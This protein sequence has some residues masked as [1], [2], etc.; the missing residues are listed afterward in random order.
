MNTRSLCLTMF[1][2]A[3]GRVHAQSPLP[4]TP[5][6]FHPPPP[7][8]AAP[9]SPPSDPT[10]Q[11][12]A[13]TPEQTPAVA[14][15]GPLPSFYYEEAPPEP[16]AP[17]PV[18]PPPAASRSRPRR[19]RKAPRP[20]R[21][22]NAG[23]PFA[24]AAG[25]G[26]L[27]HNESAHSVY[28]DHVYNVALE[29]F[30]TYDVWSPLPRTIIAAGVSL[31][32]ELLG[33][34]HDLTI[35]NHSVQGELMARFGAT[36]WLWPHLRVGVG[37]ITTRF[38]LHTPKG[39]GSSYEDRDTNVVSTFGAGLTVRTPGRLFETRGG[40][41][42]SLSLGLLI[43]GGYTLAP[44]AQLRAKPTEHSDLP[45]TTFALGGLERGGGY[46]RVMGVVRF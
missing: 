5:S 18:Q 38:R 17:P 23:A 24:F 20:R 35:R 16:V 29:L 45:R 28:S 34:D 3:A 42:A 32:S 22:G 26:V 21:Y 27:W 31:R 36:R 19:V 1:L 43:E 10:G 12:P 41:L 37:A 13:E 8:P 15:L 2:L 7:P 11:Q 33:A 14:P 46:L 25:P 30:G 40:H 9:P 6:A 44:A 4:A 39:Q